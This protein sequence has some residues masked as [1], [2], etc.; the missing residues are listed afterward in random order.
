VKRFALVT[1]A[2]SV[3]T[4]AV[5]MSGCVAASDSGDDGSE[6]TM[7]KAIYPTRDALPA[8]EGRAVKK[9]TYHNG[10]VMTNAAG[11][12]FYFIWY[13]NWAGNTATTILPDLASHLGG[14]PYWNINTTYT[15]ASAKK[16]VN[17]IT[18]GG[19]TTVAYPYGTSLSDAKI[20]QVVTDAV[21]SAALPRNANAIYFVLTS[22]DVNASSGFCTQY[23]GWHTHATIG[24][25]DLKYAFIGNPDR[26]IAS[27]AAQSTGPNGNAGADG[28]ASILAHEA[29]EAAT[30]PDLNGW[31]D[32]S[33]AE[34]GD[35]CAWTFGTQSTAA[36]GSKYN[37]TLGSRQ[38]LIQQ[39]WKA[40]TTQGCAM[41]F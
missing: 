14:S 7:D 1:G 38:Y 22:A 37:V 30:D 27:C 13:G 15:D 3:V 11:N 5:L 26:C 8:H 32:S 24:G 39:N 6:A 20:Q 16:I 29:E 33:G 34:N 36:N 41:S 18:Y 28:M 10:P 2:L 4:A 12:T 35:K 19:S 17:A 9:I 31:Y 21:N 25:S 23:C 40:G